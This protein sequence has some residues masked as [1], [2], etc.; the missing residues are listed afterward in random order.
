MHKSHRRPAAGKNLLL[1]KTITADAVVSCA[2]TAVE[3]VVLTVVCKLN[4]PP[5]IHL[6]AIYALSYLVSLNKKERIKIVLAQEP[7]QVIVCRFKRCITQQRVESRDIC[8]LYPAGAPLWSFLHSPCV[9]PVQWQ[10]RLRHR[11]KFPPALLP[12]GLSACRSQKHP[13]S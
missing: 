8:H 4:Q 5:H 12:Y 1:T 11:R 2:Q 10:P 7:G 13:R 9:L 6:P 3:A